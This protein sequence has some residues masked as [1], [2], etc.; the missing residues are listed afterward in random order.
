MKY[1]TKLIMQKFTDKEKSE[2]RAIAETIPF[3]NYY[4]KSRVTYLVLNIN[5]GVNVERYKLKLEL[6]C[7]NIDID[8]NSFKGIISSAYMKYTRKLID[9][10][11]K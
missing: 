2:A 5:R 7:K 8:S 1:K 9:K 6:M 4:T 11:I 10:R 3:V